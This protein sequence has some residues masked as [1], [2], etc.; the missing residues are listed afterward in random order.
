MERIVAD[1]IDRKSVEDEKRRDFLLKWTE[2]KG[3]K[4]TY[5]VL[6]SALLKI[7]CDKEAEGVCKLIS[8]PLSPGIL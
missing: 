4:A 3:S 7:K 2:E 6:I 1:D 8:R 5:K